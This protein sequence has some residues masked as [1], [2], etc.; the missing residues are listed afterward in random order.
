MP[1]THPTQT[2]TANDA[3]DAKLATLLD[4]CRQA[5]SNLPRPTWA[6]HIA[7]EL[8]RRSR[9]EPGHRIERNIVNFLFHI[10]P[11]HAPRGYGFDQGTELC[12]TSTPDRLVFLTAFHHMNSTGYYVGWTHHTVV[13]T[14]AFTGFNIRVTGPN[15]NG[16]KDYIL[17]TFHHW[18]STTY[19]PV[20]L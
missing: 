10:L 3:N 14:P 7:S 1:T 13:V 6:Q 19:K 17:E 8:Q 9:F 12:E 15:K 5:A 20:P 11:K 4:N 16:I 2:Q 18:L